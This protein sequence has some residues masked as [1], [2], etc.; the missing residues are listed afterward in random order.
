MINTLQAG[1][2]LSGTLMLTAALAMAAPVQAAP[3]GSGPKTYNVEQLRQT[4]LLDMD[5]IQWDQADETA[6][7]WGRRRWR[8]C[9][10]GRCRRGIRGGDI[11]A[12]ALIIGGIAAIASAATRGSRDRNEREYPRNPPVVVQQPVPVPQ[13]TLPP[14]NRATGGVSELSNAADQCSAAAQAQAGDGQID[15]ITSVSRDGDGWRVEGRIAYPQGQEAFLCGV[16]AGQI[17]YI[18]IGAGQNEEF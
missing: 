15:R 4:S 14:V 16:T 18:Q 6:N 8:R 17:D 3:L 10:W 1:K 9:G 2:T 11:L 5:D 7:R 12:G 13:Q